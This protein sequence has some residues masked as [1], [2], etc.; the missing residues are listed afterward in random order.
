[1]MVRSRSAV[2]AALLVGMMSTGVTKR[3]GAGPTPRPPAA[4]AKQAA[5][6]FREGGRLF[7]KGDYEQALAALEESYRLQP[8]PNSSLLIGRTLT[9]LG[10]H[11]E[12]FE[13][14]G[15]AEEEARERVEAGEGRYER[16]AEAAAKE[17]AQ[18]RAKLAEVTIRARG[19]PDPTE[20]EIDGE[21]TPLSADGS[22]SFV[23][24]PGGVTIVVHL[25][26]QPPI[27]RSLTLT[28]GRDVELELDLAN[29]TLVHEAPE[30]APAEP[31]PAD[32]DSPWVLPAV[33]SGS[34]TLVGAGLFAG[35]G[36]KA[37]S[38]RADLEERCAP[39]CGP[40]D[41]EDRDDGERSATIANVSLVG[42]LVA[43]AATATFTILALTDDP[44][45]T[46]EANLSIRVTPTGVGLF[47]RF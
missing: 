29:A 18:V 42:G 12:A 14:L 20:I 38:T 9:R 25:P 43:L 26:D 27:T 11:V 10:R 19:A 47:G 39:T 36:A 41:E 37:A 3:A 40:L 32:S 24:A 5:Q 44:E 15:R 16:T 31:E 21:R 46:D 45:S 22:A 2:V 23:R 1:M 8:S 34:V 17:R 6:R 28:A 4:T 13:Q 33:L 7:R 35:F 30:P